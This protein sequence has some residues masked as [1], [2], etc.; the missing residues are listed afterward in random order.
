MSAARRPLLMS[1]MYESTDHANAAIDSL[2]AAHVPPR[3]VRGMIRRDGELVSW[4]PSHTTQAAGGLLLGAF[5]GVLGA[6]GAWLAGASLPPAGLEVFAAGGLAGAVGGGLTGAGRWRESLPAGVMEHDGPVWIVV[7][8]EPWAA[9]A[10]EVL[11]ESTA[12]RSV[13][14]GAAPSEIHRQAAPTTG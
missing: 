2:M 3:R 13:E 7:E 1:A 12:A 4:R 11:R 6:V 5:I 8:G 9:R 10:A 14:L